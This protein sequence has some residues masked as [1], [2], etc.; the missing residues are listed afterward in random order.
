M[1]EMFIGTSSVTLFARLC[2]KSLDLSFV[3]IGQHQPRSNLHQLF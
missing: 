1:D 2:S 3:S